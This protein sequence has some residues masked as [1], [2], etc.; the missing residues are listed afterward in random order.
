ME[1]GFKA[2]MAR[3]AELTM[4]SEG[5]H[6]AYR[7]Y[8]GKSSRTGRGAALEA[9]IEQLKKEL[10]DLQVA[11]KRLGQEHANLVARNELLVQ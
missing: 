10:A 8:L 7:L 5:L 3:V 6:H 11:N 2:T 1:A 4:K 9:D